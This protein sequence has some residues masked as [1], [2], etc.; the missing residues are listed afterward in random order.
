MLVFRDQPGS[1]I[2]YVSK[3]LTFAPSSC[4]LAH[5]L[6]ERN[7]YPGNLGYVRLLPGHWFGNGCPA[8]A[9]HEGSERFEALGQFLA[10]FAG[11][12]FSGHPL[13]L[14]N[15][16]QSEGNTPLADCKG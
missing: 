2:Y 16:G 6:H 15:V 12:S 5:P 8:K 7:P 13:H 4:D 3:V 1:D 14:P 9:Q 11:S 10:H